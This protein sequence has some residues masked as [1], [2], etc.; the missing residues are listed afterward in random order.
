MMNQR[1]R[2]GSFGVFL[3]LAMAGC[4]SADDEPEWQYDQEDMEGVVLGTWTGTFTPEGGSPS[5][6]ALTIRPHDEPVRELSCGSRTFADDGSGP[7]VGLRCFDSSSLRV[8][9]ALTIGEGSES[10]GLDGTFDVYGTTLTSGELRISL[11]NGHLWARWEDEVWSPCDLWFDE[12]TN[13]TCTLDE[14]AE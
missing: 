13:G 3:V 4:S 1:V 2:M 11:A 7:G 12:A 10:Q 6:L 5:A 8:S 14:R 9:A